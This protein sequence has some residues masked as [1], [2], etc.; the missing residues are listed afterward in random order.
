MNADELGSGVGCNTF[1]DH[2]C[3]CRVCSELIIVKD[4]PCTQRTEVSRF[5]CPEMGDKK[6]GVTKA[7]RHTK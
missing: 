6:E 7:T 4:G 5:T 1:Y 3:N 2:E